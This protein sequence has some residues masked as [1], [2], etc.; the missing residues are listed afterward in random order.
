MINQLIN[1]ILVYDIRFVYYM[2]M[3]LYEV[4][5]YILNSI[6]IRENKRIKLLNIKTCVL[7]KKGRT[8]LCSS[9]IIYLV[10]L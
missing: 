3:K 2:E 5:I 4:R 10:F 7:K 9:F 6:L 1:F 8:P